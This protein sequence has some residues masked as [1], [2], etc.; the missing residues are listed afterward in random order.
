MS[1]HESPGPAAVGRAAPL[2]GVARPA[3]RLAVART[4]PPSVLADYCYVLSLLQLGAAA[5]TW[6]WIVV[7]A[8]EQQLPFPAANSPPWQL[9]GAIM[10]LRAAGAS[11][12]AV[13]A[14]GG[15]HEYLAFA[16]VCARHRVAM[17]AT[18][19]EIVPGAALLLLPTLRRGPATALSGACAQALRYQAFVAPHIDSA[20]AA[21]AELLRRSPCVA[22]I[23]DATMV[24]NGARP[25]A[26][27]PEIGNM[28]LA[29]T[30]I[31]ALDELAA[32]L[33]CI[34][35]ADQ[36]PALG[37]LAQLGLGCTTVGVDSVIGDVSLLGQRWRPTRMSAFQ[38]WRSLLG[39]SPAER[40]VYT[41]WLYHT[42]WGR[43]FAS[44]YRGRLAERGMPAGARR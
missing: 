1:H 12:I 10:A 2:A 11:Q 19:S 31:V 14:A 36:L 40:E 20:V 21:V 34:D 22:A 26:G 33:L 32:R 4:A 15:R 42:G 39:G 44:Y 13:C 5:A 24:G 37:Q 30:D 3:G 6:P 38:R 43:L 8:I 25:G 23:M 41:S 7:P 35:A 9:E 18:P 16:E 27:L 28:L 17:L 29:S